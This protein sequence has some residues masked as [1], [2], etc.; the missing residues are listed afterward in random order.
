M[1]FALAV[2][3][4]VAAAVPATVVLTAGIALA[5]GTVLTAAGVLAA[6]ATLIP[7]AGRLSNILAGPRPA[8]IL[9][10]STQAGT[11][12]AFG[13]SMIFRVPC[14]ATTGAAAPTHRGAIA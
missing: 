6:C 13:G 12:S 8:S 7:C 11:D 5:V 14:I 1:V 3:A 4:A 10:V 2:P 9:H